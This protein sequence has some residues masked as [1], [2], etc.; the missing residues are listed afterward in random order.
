MFALELPIL[1]DK[2][3]NVLAV[4]GEFKNY[5]LVVYNCTK[6]DRALLGQTKIN[7][8]SEIQIDR[9][10]RD[11]RI[12]LKNIIGKIKIWQLNILM[13]HFGKQIGKIY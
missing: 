1:E 10:G 11:E 12:R 6:K 13:E 3:G 8:F 4:L 2:F 9:F 5:W 7:K